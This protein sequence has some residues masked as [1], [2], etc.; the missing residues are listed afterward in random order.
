MRFYT[1]RLPSD[2]VRHLDRGF[3]D[4]FRDMSSG[5]DKCSNDPRMSVLEFDDRYEVQMDLPG[6]SSENVS[7]EME[8]GILR[9][10]GKRTIPDTDSTARVVAD[11]RSR[12][13]FCRTLKVEREIEVAQ[14]DAELNAG[15]LQIRLPKKSEVQPHR[16]QIRNAT[17]THTGQS[18]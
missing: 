3:A 1:H 8:D 9:V 7:V 14:I 17:A 11:E 12:A 15:V 18:S 4:F 6:V 16:I 5:E 2:L 13:D 10:F